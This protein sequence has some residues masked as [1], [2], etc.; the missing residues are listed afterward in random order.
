MDNEGEKKMNYPTTYEEAERLESVAARL[1]ATNMANS[2]KSRSPEILATLKKIQG[3]VPL[4]R[5]RH[6]KGTLEPGREHE[7]YEVKGIVEDVNT[8]ICYV[9][10]VGNYGAYAGQEGLRVLAGP[11]SFLRPIDRMDYKGVRFIRLPDEEEVYI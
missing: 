5:Y 9:R 1:V 8:G 10:Y 3:I 6:F 11:D 7:F 4:G 2:K